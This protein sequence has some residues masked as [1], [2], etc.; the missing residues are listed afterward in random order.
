MS[1]AEARLSVLQTPTQEVVSGNPDFNL[2]DYNPYETDADRRKAEQERKKE[3]A[4]RK[5]AE[6]KAKQEF[7]A[8]LNNAKG[9]WEAG[10]RKTPPTSQQ[11]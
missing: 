7:K 6:T 3:E 10:R 4:A 2:D 9:V 11:G 5:R 1:E 8:E